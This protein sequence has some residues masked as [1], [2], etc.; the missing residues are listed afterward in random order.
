MTIRSLAALFALCSLSTIAFTGCAAE[1]ATSDD[2]S[3]SEGDELKKKNPC[4]T[5]K[6]ASGTHCEAEQVQCIKAPC[7]PIAACVKDDPCATVKCA[8]GTHCES[9]DVQC[10]KAPSPPVAECVPNDPC[11]TVKCAAGT[12]CESHQVEC[13]TAPCPP[14]AG[15]YPDAAQCKMDSDCKVV[16]NYCGGCSCDA[17]PAIKLPTTCSNPVMCFVQPCLN[18][19][20]ACDNGVC[21]VH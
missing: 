6:C 8:S 14:I 2:Q 4:A 3:A 16:D 18:R 10:K 1:D 5:V 15:C 13:I 20:A 7:P 17:L 9:H 11:M 12:H 21:V 19:T